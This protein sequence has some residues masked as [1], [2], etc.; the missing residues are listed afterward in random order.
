MALEAKATLKADVTLAGWTDPRP[1]DA[2]KF[3]PAGSETS[4][5]FEAGISFR[6]C[7]QHGEKDFTV[8][9]VK[10]DQ[11]G[12]CRS[13]L[14]ALPMGSPVSIEYTARD[15]KYQLMSVRALQPAK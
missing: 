7:V 14:E 10:T 3:M 5:A 15:G 13:V 6:V 8:L 9:Q 11:V 4:I 1:Y 12:R 2:G